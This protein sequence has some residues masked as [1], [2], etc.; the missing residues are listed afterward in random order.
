[1]NWMQKYVGAALLVIVVLCSTIDVSAQK[2][3]SKKKS[4]PLSE[5]EIRESEY[6]FIEAEKYFTLGDYAKAHNQFLECLEIVPNNPAAYFKLSEIAVKNEEIDKA[7]NYAL[8]ALELDQSNKYFYLMVANIYTEKG[9]FVNAA[10]YYEEM[11]AAV[12][13]SN[14]YLFELAAI[15]LYQDKLEEALQSYNRAEDVFGVNEQTVFQKQKIYLGLNELD[16]AI[17][18]GE[19]LIDTY[20]GEPAYVIALSNVLIA[21]GKVDKAQQLIENMLNNFPQNGQ[22]K[23]ILSDLYKNK[24]EY[25]KA[26]ELLFSAFEDSNVNPDI[27]VQI[28]AAYT[29]QISQA[30][31]LNNSNQTLEDN[32][33]QLALKTIE[34]HPDEANTFAVYADLL[35]ALQKKEDALKNYLQTVKLAPDNFQVWQNIFQL[36]SERNDVDGMIAHCEQA[37]ELFPNQSVVHM[38][39]GLALSQKGEYDEAVAVLEQGKLLSSSNQYQTN[40]FCSLLG[41]AYNSLRNYAKSDKN[42]DEALEINP[43]DYQTLNNYSYYLSLRGE[44]LEKAEEMAQKVVKDNPGNPTYIDTYAWVLYAM[45]KYKDAKKQ[46]EKVIDREG[47]GAVPYDHYG[48]ILYQ[49]GEIDKAVEQ[50]EKAR[51]INPELDNIDKKIEERRIYK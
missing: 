42:Y 45:G 35:Y 50:W 28:I 24:G 6:L 46:M 17:K 43:N 3:R 19:K 40:I 18:E 33:I 20:P 9:D 15:Y 39:Y 5:K 27:K 37:L 47:L 22:A 14:E 29:Q 8:S 26:E 48:D 1:M 12:D 30:R 4:K 38:Y 2:S 32:T 41:N 10:H 49:L 31:S 25:E 7:L 13:G 16:L 44:K 34:L 51:G 21:N 36:D 11:I 23:L